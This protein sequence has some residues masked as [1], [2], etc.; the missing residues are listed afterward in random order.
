MI[1]AGQLQEIAGCSQKVADTYAKLINQFGAKYGIDTPARLTMFIAQ[2]A[3]ESAR[4][5]R[6]VENLNYSADGLKLTWPKRFDTA[7]ANVMARNPELI[8]NHVYSGRMGNVLPS[9]G[10]RFRGRGLIQLTGRDNYKAFEQS[11]GHPVTVKPELLEQPEYAL[12]S[13]MWYW[14]ANTLNRFADAGDLR[15]CTRAING[16]Y[17]GLDDRQALF[18][19]ATKA[20][21]WS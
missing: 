16:G 12:Q 19:K 14:D 7:A 21:R 9:D 2:V 20:L 8:A 3:H 10:W 17:N 6:T 4:F 5:S 18:N 11:S 13:A 15:G 1:S